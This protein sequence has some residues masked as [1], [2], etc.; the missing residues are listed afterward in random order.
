VADYPLNTGGNATY[1]TLVTLNGVL[2]T[3]PA[4]KFFYGYDDYV[5]NVIKTNSQIT[6]EQNVIGSWGG[7]TSNTYKRPDD[8]GGV[9]RVITG[10]G[11]PG[12][13][14]GFYN[15]NGGGAG[16]PTY[17]QYHQTDGDLWFHTTAMNTW[18]AGATP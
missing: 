12:T 6:K 1:L 15:A 13:M 18:A 5:Q 10:T 16:V 17:D 11:A 9:M 8:A 7:F 2:H 4:N 3:G 14:P